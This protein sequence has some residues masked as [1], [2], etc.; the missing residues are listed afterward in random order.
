MRVIQ[1]T[2]EAFNQFT[3]WQITD[4]KIFQKIVAL[5]KETERNPFEGSGK[6]EPLKHDLQGYWSRRIN[7]EHR[8]VYKVSEN[9]ILIIACK[10]HY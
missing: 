7:L 9:S 3:E 10:Y 4:K 1:F 5:I 8:L 6:P 2:N